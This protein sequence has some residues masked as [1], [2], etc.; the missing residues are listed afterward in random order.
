MPM[1]D[2]QRRAYLQRA[3]VSQ[4]QIDQTVG[5]LPIHEGS[6]RASGL[7][8]AHA[9][10]VR[11]A[12]RQVVADASIIAAKYSAIA[13]GADRDVAKAVGADEIATD[14]GY[15]EEL[16]ADEYTLHNPFGTAQDKAQVVDAMLKGMISYDGMGSAGFEALGQS[17]QVHGDTAVAV[18]DYRMRASSRARNVETGAVYQQDVGG[19]YRITNTYVHRNDRWQAATSQMTAVPPEQKFVLTPN[20]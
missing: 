3:G 8:R 6:Y 19:T 20:P 17:L 5:D 16:F 13:Q 12:V 9:E 2:E 11:A 4:Q 10:Q 14:R 1:Q 18:G 7:S 15:L